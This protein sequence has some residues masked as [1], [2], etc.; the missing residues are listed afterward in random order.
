MMFNKLK[1]YMERIFPFMKNNKIEE[2]LIN[3]ITLC[4]SDRKLNIDFSEEL[5]KS[6]VK[7]VRLSMLLGIATYIIFGLKYEIL[8]SPDKYLFYRIIGIIEFS[9]VFVLT[10]F[11]LYKKYS[12]FI[13]SGL[14]LFGG[15]NVLMISL[16]NGNNLYVGLILTSIYAHSLLRFRFVF[17]SLTTWILVSTYLTIISIS[18]DIPEFILINNTF[19]LVTANLLGMVASYSIEYYMRANF[20][21]SRQLHEKR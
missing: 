12:Q 2:G 13:I 4:F 9:T 10:Y 1:E 17:A 11:S 8:E 3:P 19:F 14:I 21:K 18:P 7:V 20:W 15:F 16:D 6:S 5:A